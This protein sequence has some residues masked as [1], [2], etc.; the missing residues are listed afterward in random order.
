M[1]KNAVQSVL[2]AQF[3]NAFKKGK[4]ERKR[5]NTRDKVR[6][7]ETCFFHKLSRQNTETC[8]CFFSSIF[9]VPGHLYS[10][11]F[12]FSFYGRKLFFSK[13]FVSI[14]SSSSSLLLS[15]SFLEVHQKEEGFVNFG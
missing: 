10:S 12:T 14:T 9:A 6:G 11:P 15:S 8:E 1:N 13:T 3:F 2:L 7:I 5:R 4:A